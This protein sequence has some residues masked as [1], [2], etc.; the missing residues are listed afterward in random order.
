MKE[1][2]NTINFIKGLA[3]IAV[4][5]IHVQFPGVFG[6]GIIALARSAVALFFV[7]SGYYLYTGD[8]K[9]EFQ[10]LVK[11]TK[12]I[13]IMTGI[14]FLV[15]FVWESFVR[16]VGSGTAS[17]LSYYKEL[18]TWQNLLNV[19]FFSYDPVVGHL[20]FLLAL[21]QG[22]L[23]LLLVNKIKGMK[24]ACILAFPLLEV[25]VVVMALS[26]ILKW[27]IEMFY[28]RSVW[29]Y[30]L[31]FICLGYALKKYEGLLQQKISTAALMIGVGVGIALTIVERFLIGNLQL[32]N[33][34]LILIFSL[35]ILACRYPKLPLPK[36]G[37]VLGTK[38][39]SE[40]YIYHWIVKEI[41]NKIQRALSLD[42]WFDWVAPIGVFLVTLG[43][44]I[45]LVL[46]KEL[47]QKNGNKIIQRKN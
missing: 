29:F 9:V 5:F 17:V 8:S 7:I 22:Y 2:N 24:V 40:I 12:R 1:Q 45:I 39:S 28:F 19:V 44:V 23:L 3:C 11:R 15:Y 32:F 46:I 30:G 42:A 31:P 43:G 35:F 13:A 6:Q 47:I 38:Y 21:L 16:F 14:A 10:K 18:F 34:T 36:A 20:W 26:I 41:F 25:Q 27:K 4:V 37:I 33:G